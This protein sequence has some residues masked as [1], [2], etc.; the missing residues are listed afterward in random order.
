[1]ARPRKSKEQKQAEKDAAE[2]A[3]AAMEEED[4]ISLAP[5]E[6]VLIKKLSMK[7]TTR[8]ESLDKK[9]VSEQSQPGSKQI[10]VHQP[11]RE[12]VINV[13][14]HL[15]A[16]PNYLQKPEPSD[17]GYHSGLGT[18]TASVCS[19]DS[20]GSSLG[21]LHDFLQEFIAL[22]GNTLIDQSGA[23]G[24]T[25]H[26]LATHPPELIEQQLNVLL[27]EYTLELLQLPKESVSTS[28]FWSR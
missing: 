17:S 18:D 20:V 3:Y 26:A 12:Y 19:M 11:R 2:A 22:F 27:K 14:A 15:Y 6:D 10:V 1:M 7:D 21:L 24:W 9:R 13:N 8:E 16:N 4:F 28:K 23:R 25:E 5:K